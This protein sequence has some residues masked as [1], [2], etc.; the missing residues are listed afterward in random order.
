MR[1][2]R[3]LFVGAACA[4]LLAGC[5]SA[6]ARTPSSSSSPSPY[7]QS[8]LGQIDQGS[9][10][11]LTT[12]VDF[13][14]TDQFGQQVSLSQYRGKVVLLSFNDDM[15]TTVCP[16]TDKVQLLATQALGSAAK[17]VVLLG[18]NANPDFT[19]VADVKNYSVVHGMMNHW[20]FLTGSLP[21]L[22]AVWKQFKIEVQVVKG[23]IDHT[24]ALYII[25]ANGVPVRVYLIS[26]E[27]GTVPLEADAVANGLSRVLPSH[28][29]VRKLPLALGQ[30][31]ASP[32]G[33]RS[34]P[35]LGGGGPV[36]ISPGSSNVVVFLASWA[37]GF[38]QG[39]T[40][41]DTYDATATKDGLPQAVAVDVAP[42]E[43]DALAMTK[44]LDTL[45]SPPSVA[46]AVDETGRVAD[47]FGVQNIPWITLEKDG[48][49]VWSHDGF[50]DA[51]TL[52]QDI[53]AHLQ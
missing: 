24:P 5:G 26:P 40:A 27:Y 9:A 3:N 23:A 46:V 4:V 6:P 15:C 47:A 14:L 36:P 34:L 18:V 12:P 52:T 10:T 49:V 28:P 13:T 8:E 16:L 51:A 1:F 19:T 38:A 20:R 53:K 42:V 22:K 33:V 41:L 50:L 39:I 25:N 32:A 48:K 44:A 37:P 45:P 11:G 31:V 29:A 21:Q 2:V 35:S 7:T 17:G 30:P 43:P